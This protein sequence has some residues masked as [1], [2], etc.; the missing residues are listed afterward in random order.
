MKNFNVTSIS[1][2]YDRYF[3]LFEKRKIQILKFHV[4]K[5]ADFEEEQRPSIN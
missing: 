5:S 1:A 3:L 2:I 4:N